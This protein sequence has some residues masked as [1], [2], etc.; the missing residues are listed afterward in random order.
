MDHCL[1]WAFAQVAYEAV[2]AV[3][4]AAGCHTG[5]E[6][7]EGVDTE[8]VAGAVDAADAAGV[9]GAEHVARVEDVGAGAAEDEDAEAD[10]AGVGEEKVRVVVDSDTM[11][12][13][14]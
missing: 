8:D 10:H 2:Y 7:A 5:A 11:A 12:A 1:A 3:A 13:V 4:K 9:V 6:G 14:Q